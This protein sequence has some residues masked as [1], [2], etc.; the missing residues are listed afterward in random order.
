MWQGV[1]VKKIDHLSGRY[2]SYWNAFLYIVDAIKRGFSEEYKNALKNIQF[3][4]LI[5]LRNVSKTSSLAELITNQLQ[6]EVPAQKVQEILEGK[7]KD[8]T[9]IILDGYDEYTRG[10]NEDI[11][12]LIE[13]PVN[14]CF[15]ILTSRFG[16]YLRKEFRDRMDGE[17]IIEGFSEENIAK[18]SELYL[19]SKEM[20]DDFLK[21]A[22]RSKIYKLLHVPI[23][24]LMSCMVFA[25]KGSLP[26]TQTK[27][28]GIARDLIMD[29]TTLKTFGKKSAELADL[30]SWL[31]ILGQ[32]SWEALQRGEKQLL[33]DKVSTNLLWIMH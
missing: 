21:E 30:D 7:H 32:M 33:L 8:R 13:S 10:T 6:N 4:F 17:L 27:L 16:E 5:P 26:K 22:K 24:L 2:T 12:R 31:D 20:S 28:F 19:G 14:K 11:D 1:C 15:L 23:V 9:L 29:R 3:C 18:C 25:E